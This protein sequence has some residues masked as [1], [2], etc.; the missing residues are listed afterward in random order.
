MEL[1]VKKIYLLL[2]LVLS[3]CGNPLS[4]DDKSKVNEGFQP[5]VPVEAV[6]PDPPPVI[7]AP[8][9]GDTGFKISP[10]AM[11]ATG[12]SLSM[13]ASINPNDRLVKG[14]NVSA[15]LSVSKR[16]LR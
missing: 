15:R 3:G 2:P 6:A 4:G 12:S 1:A 16:A 11:R 8:V 7:P 13:K 9:G 10:G 5:G 14:S